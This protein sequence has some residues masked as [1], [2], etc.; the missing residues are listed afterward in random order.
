MIGYTH[1]RDGKRIWKEGGKSRN[2]KSKGEKKNFIVV[3]K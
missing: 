2:G 3:E 1:K